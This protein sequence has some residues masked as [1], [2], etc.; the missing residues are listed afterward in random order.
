MKRIY[1]NLDPTDF[2]SE[3]LTRSTERLLV[4]SCG[5]VGW[6]DLGEPRR[7]IAALAEFGAESRR[8]TI[9]S[10]VKCGLTMEQI[11]TLSSRERTDVCRSESVP[12]SSC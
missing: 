7:F 5:E 2:S 6:S 3:V 1:D 8:A 9:D 10:C 11:I 4:A 12:L